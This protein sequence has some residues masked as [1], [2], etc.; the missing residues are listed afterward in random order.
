MADMSTP[1]VSALV[2]GKDG[3]RGVVERRAEPTETGEPQ[4]LIRLSDGRQVL[5]AT[6]A[7]TAQNDGS[8][9]LPL[10]VAELESQR[11]VGTEEVDRTLVLPATA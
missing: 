4:V 8:Y 5:V 7:L 10:S 11:R 6:D 9:Y 2:V 1:A 3:L